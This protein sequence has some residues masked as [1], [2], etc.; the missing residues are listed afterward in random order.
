V[1]S[2]VGRAEVVCCIFYVLTVLSYCKAI[3]HGCGTSLTSSGQTKWNLVILCLIFNLCSMLSKEQG[4]VGVG[5]C[6][7]FDI[8][9]HL[10]PLWESVVRPKGGKKRTEGK[11]VAGGGSGES[12]DS[13]NEEDLHKSKSSTVQDSEGQGKVHHS[14]PPRINGMTVGVR[15]GHGKSKRSLS[16]SSGTQRRGQSDGQEQAST[17]GMVTKR[18]G[19]F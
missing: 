12:S 16:P 3:S 9:L 13:N 10:K 4:I 1:A 11:D 6:A 5:V 17:L 7:S 8:L 15:Q 19:M 2:I 18:V 14:G